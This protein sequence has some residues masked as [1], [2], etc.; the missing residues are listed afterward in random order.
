MWALLNYLY[1]N[2]FPASEPFD[3]GFDLTHNCINQNVLLAAQSLLRP[4]MIRRLKKEVATK[5]PIKTETLI[6]CR[7]APYQTHWYKML[8]ASH[9]GLLDKLSDEARASPDEALLKETADGDL[10]AGD[11]QVLHENAQ[12]DADGNIVVQ[13]LARIH[14]DDTP[15]P[16]EQ[17]K[18]GRLRKGEEDEEDNFGLGDSVHVAANAGNDWRKLMNLMIQLRKCWSVT[19]PDTRCMH[20][21]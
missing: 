19:I 17:N 2:L 18:K 13:Q 6:K 21:H 12:L 11:A 10:S 4:I 3:K 9:S 16:I 15:T 8:L 7:L 14:H 5:L 20:L 1:P